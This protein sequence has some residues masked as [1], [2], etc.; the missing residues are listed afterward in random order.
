MICRDIQSTS[1]RLR[2]AIL[3]FTPE[4]WTPTHWF[5]PNCTNNRFISISQ[6]VIFWQLTELNTFFLKHIF[7]I[8]PAHLLNLG[9]FALLVL[10]VAPSVRQYYTYITDTRC[11]RVGTQCWVFVATIITET[12]ICIKFGTKIFVNAQ[13]SNI[14][15]WLLIQVIK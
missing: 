12:L 15:I 4:S 14:L 8:P 2:R 9:R 10:V 1:R 7:E 3:Q 6:L 5:D 13:L 11:K